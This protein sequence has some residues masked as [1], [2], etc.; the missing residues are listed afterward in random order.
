MAAHNIQKG[1]RLG[2]YK[3]GR[4]LFVD[5]NHKVRD[6]QTNE[7]MAEDQHYY[8]ESNP[9]TSRDIMRGYDMAIE[10][11]SE[12]K[13]HI[14]CTITTFTVTKDRGWMKS[15]YLPTYI[16]VVLMHKWFI[17]HKLFDLCQRSLPQYKDKPYELFAS[18][19]SSNIDFFPISSKIQW[20]NYAYCIGI[21]MITTGN[22]FETCNIK[23]ALK[24]AKKAQLIV[25]GISE[26][27]S[28][29]QHNEMLANTHD[30]SILKRILTSIKNPEKKMSSVSDTPPDPPT[31]SEGGACAKS[32]E[33]GACAK[34]GEGGACAKSVEESM[35]NLTMDDKTLEE[36]IDDQVTI[37]YIKSD[38]Y[39]K[40]KKENKEKV[41]QIIIQVCQQYLDF[42]G[43]FGTM[44]E[45]N[46]FICDDL[47]ERI[48]AKYEEE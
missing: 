10:D 16:A 37:D 46:T 25:D 35:D 6:L 34:S 1:T 5:Y 14:G 43:E 32:G 47:H 39:K 9:V 19:V 4:I 45:Y 18:W 7:I 33:G 31:S 26:G 2:F 17:E 48:I 20:L 44:D 15:T 11:Y 28:N 36:S 8:K 21:E 23:Q 41:R 40:I 42:Y 24:H 12:I 22:S 38:L 27:S 3:D 29:D 30:I 13:D